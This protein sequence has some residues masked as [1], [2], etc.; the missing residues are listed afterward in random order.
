ML[1]QDVNK[2]VIGEGKGYCQSTDHSVM[3]LRAV[4]VTS[5]SSGKWLVVWVRISK[6]QSE[7][8]YRDRSISQNGSLLQIQALRCKGSTEQ[9]GDR[10]FFYLVRL[11][12]CF[13]MH[14]ADRRCSRV[15][16]H[17][18][19]TNSMNA[20]SLRLAWQL[21]CPRLAFLAETNRVF[22]RWPTSW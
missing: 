22:L 14:T 5:P 9:P 21:L 16:G 17:G 3:S 7:V 18:H 10:V 11:P 4:M 19:N 2:W 6:N 15:K 12:R 20:I 8:K 13:R 1:S